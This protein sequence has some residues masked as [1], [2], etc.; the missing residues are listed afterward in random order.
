[1]RA[2]LAG[3]GLVA[4]IAAAPMAG[5]CQLAPAERPDEPAAYVAL[6]RA[7]LAAPPAPARFDSAAEAEFLERVNGE[8]VARGLD[9]LELRRGLVAPA[10]FHSLDQIWNG[11]HGHA[12]AA[13]R[14][15]AE[16]IAAL[17][18]RLVSTASRENVAYARG[19]H[20]RD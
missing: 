14:R 20:D 6:A 11:I 18:R 8:R 9:R 7:C 1:M 15:P 13:G 19:D 4:A 10:R 12:G 3:A 5:A 16:R 2:W 17:D